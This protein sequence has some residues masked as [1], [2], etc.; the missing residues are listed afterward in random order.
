MS[1]TVQGFDDETADSRWSFGR[2][3][4][5]RRLISPCAR[6]T[7]R[8]K[9]LSTSFNVTFASSKQLMPG[10]E[11]QKHNAWIRRSTNLMNCTAGNRGPCKSEALLGRTVRTP[12][13]TALAASEEQIA[14]ATA[15]PSQQ[16]CRRRQGCDDGA[17]RRGDVESTTYSSV[18]PRSF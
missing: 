7:A 15:E 18:K 4:G 5:W 11:S 16:L 3:L 13:G 2:K 17:W 12:V 14:R 6:V 1:F 8:Q 10:L 9:K